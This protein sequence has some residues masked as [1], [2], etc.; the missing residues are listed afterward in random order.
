MSS[1]QTNKGV[2]LALGVDRRP[3]PEPGAALDGFHNGSDN[4]SIPGLDTQCGFMKSMEFRLSSMGVR[5]LA[6]EAGCS[7]QNLL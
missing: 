3:P 2:P 5:E 4:I 7:R 1:A 6:C